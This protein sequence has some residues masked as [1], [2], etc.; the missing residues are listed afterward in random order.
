[1]KA[2]S[3]L[4]Q[5]RPTITASSFPQA[6]MIF[7]SGFIEP[8]QQMADKPASRRLVSRAAERGKFCPL[9]V[10]IMLLMSTPE[11]PDLHRGGRR[12]SRRDALLLT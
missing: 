11:T 10:N 6:C 8:G 5:H 2:L 3:C 7:P 1:M 12:C 9:G 4:G